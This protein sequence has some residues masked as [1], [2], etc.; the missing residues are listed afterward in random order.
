MQHVGG[1]EH[2]YLRRTEGLMPGWA[3]D[4]PGS[5]EGI[6]SGT[7]KKGNRKHL[8]PMRTDLMAPASDQAKGLLS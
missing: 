3:L 4:L 8:G 2:V 5:L 1:W 7:G 6:K